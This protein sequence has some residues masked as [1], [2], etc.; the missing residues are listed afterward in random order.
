MC[1]TASNWTTQSKLSRRPDVCRD[2]APKHSEQP[3]VSPCLW[4]RDFEMYFFLLFCHRL[5]RHFSWIPGHTCEV[6]ECVLLPL[7]TR[8]APLRQPFA[9]LVRVIQGSQSPLSC[10]DPALPSHQQYP[11]D[12]MSHLSAATQLCIL[13]SSAEHARCDH[14]FLTD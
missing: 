5:S 1:C 14:A 8:R 4:M 6:G 13:S 9:V 3:G 7:F 10:S 11:R 12:S 2:E